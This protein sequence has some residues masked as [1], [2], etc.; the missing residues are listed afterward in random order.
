MRA[1][2]DPSLEADEYLRAA[3]AA[4]AG[5]LEAVIDGTATAE[6][7]KGAD[8]FGWPATHLTLREPSGARVGATLLA[9]EL[10]NEAE[11]EERFRGL[12]TALETVRDWR[13]AVARLFATIRPWCETL[14]GVSAVAEETIRAAEGESGEYEI[15]QLVVTAGRWPMR[16]YPMAAWVV[17]WEGL[18]MMSGMGRAALY[19][20]RANSAWYHIPDNIPYQEVPLTEA[21][22]REL[23]GAI[24]HA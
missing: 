18:V 4:R 14:P 1:T 19:Y 24:L 15:S 20:S 3:V 17:G 2:I 12:K 8:R 22:F 13:V 11:V 21:L 16:I 10:R 6:W 5:L 9:A 23:A 7:R